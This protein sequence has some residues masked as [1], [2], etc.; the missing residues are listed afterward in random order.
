MRLVN[1]HMGMGT[2][3]QQTETD[4][5]GASSAAVPTTNAPATDV[6]DHTVPILPSKIQLRPPFSFRRGAY[7]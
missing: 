3:N 6:S 5:D 4:H 7:F 1:M 2:R